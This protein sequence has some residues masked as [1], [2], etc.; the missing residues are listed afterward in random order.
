MLPE[1][2]IL[3]WVNLTH[4]EKKKLTQSGIIVFKF[5]LF[6]HGDVQSWKFPP[7]TGPKITVAWELHMYLT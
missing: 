2:E 5:L 4:C 7:R 1:D 6:I 3:V